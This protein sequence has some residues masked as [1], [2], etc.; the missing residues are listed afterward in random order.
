VHRA[1]LGPPL[2]LPAARPRA[3]SPTS[4]RTTRAR[5]WASRPQ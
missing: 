3:S 5:R 1:D 4:V 2:R